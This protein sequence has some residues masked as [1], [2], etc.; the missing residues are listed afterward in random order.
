MFKAALVLL[1]LSLSITSVAQDSGIDQVSFD[2]SEVRIMG[3]SNLGEY[4]C[5]LVDLS[6][7]PVK[8]VISK[9]SG[10]R[11]KLENNILQVNSDGIDCQN[12]VMNNDFRKAIK[13][14]KHPYILL[15]LQEFTLKGAVS[16]MP[17]QKEVPSRIAITMAGVTKNYEVSLDYFKFEG[18]KITLKGSK[19]LAMSDYD[20]DAPTALFGMVKAEDAVKIDFLITFNLGET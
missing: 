16:N 2:N 10:F 13:A 15:E 8:E 4:Q 20:I 14:D 1:G 11:V 12:Q 9:V 6:N 3:R 17:L 5:L 7:C 19:E 18:E